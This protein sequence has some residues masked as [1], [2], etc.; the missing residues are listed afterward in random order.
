[1]LIGRAI[2]RD[3]RVRRVFLARIRYY[4]YFQLSP[5]AQS[6]EILAFW[7]GSRGSSPAL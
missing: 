2:D 5:D 6:V 7:H 4:V 1:M 3:P